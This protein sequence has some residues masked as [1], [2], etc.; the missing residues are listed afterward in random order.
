MGLI[1]PKTLYGR[2]AVFLRG[3]SVRL[4]L[5]GGFIVSEAPEDAMQLLEHLGVFRIDGQQHCLIGKYG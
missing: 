1:A 5:L 3:Y 2:S 4:A